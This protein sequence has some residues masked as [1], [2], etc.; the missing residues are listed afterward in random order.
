MGVLVL[1][2]TALY[3]AFSEGRPSPLAPLRLQY[4]D[5]AHWQREWLQG[6]VLEKQMSYWRSQLSGAPPV[7]QL[8][9]DFPRPEVQR[10]QGVTRT[11][12][13][14][15]GLRVDLG[16]LARHEGASV[17]MVLLSA[18]QILL[19]YYT[20]EDDVVVGSNIANRNRVEVEGLIGFFINQLVLR[21]DLSGNPTVTELLRRTR[22]TTMDAYVHQDLSFDLLVAELQPERTMSR[23]PL[24]QVLFTLQNAPMPPLEITGIRLTPYD[25]PTPTAKFDLVMTLFETESSFVLAIECDRDL[26]STATIDRMLGQYEAIVDRMV[27]APACRIGQIYDL[28]AGEEEQQKKARGIALREISSEKLHRI[29]RRAALQ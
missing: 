19:C 18:F 14:R 25:M 4:A 23:S 1:E 16:A 27:A 15:Q 7:L 24:Y 20:R 21:T 5:F 22:K 13:L 8:P 28:L 17:F 10:F 11:K 12:T 3:E 26:F 2:L 29:Q 6:E 9:T